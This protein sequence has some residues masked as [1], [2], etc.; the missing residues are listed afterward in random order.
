MSGEPSHLV[1]VVLFG[2]A[3]VLRTRR[4]I[5]VKF[6]VPKHGFVEKRADELFMFIP[7][8]DDVPLESFFRLLLELMNPL[9]DTV[10]DVFNHTVE[11]HVRQHVRPQKKDAEG[12]GAP[13]PAQPPVTLKPD[14]GPG[15]AQ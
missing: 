5:D 12:K 7:Q 6:H 13:P 4:R 3:P 1:H 15:T 10:S 9:F 14:K 11:H 2:T 8:L